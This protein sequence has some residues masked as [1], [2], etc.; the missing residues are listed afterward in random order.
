MQQED[1]KEMRIS[2]D[3]Q[4]SAFLSSV[5]GE[6]RFLRVQIPNPPGRGKDTLMRVTA[7]GRWH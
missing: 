1:N 3:C 7:I 4:E 5:P 6:A 2:W